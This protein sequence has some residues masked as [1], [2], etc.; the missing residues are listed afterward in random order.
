MLGF[1][2]IFVICIFH[3]LASVTPQFP[4]L[5]AGA[6]PQYPLRYPKRVDLIKSTTTEVS[7]IASG[8]ARGEGLPALAPGH[9]LLPPSKAGILQYT[10]PLVYSLYSKLYEQ[11]HQLRH[12]AVAAAAAAAHTNVNFN[13]NADTISATK[14]KLDENANANVKAIANRQAQ[15]QTLTHPKFPQVNIDDVLYF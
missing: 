13:A 6:D 10:N 11:Q 12:T 3:A 2:T 5:R 8:D 4:D 15:T 9:K 14:L 7:N 1:S